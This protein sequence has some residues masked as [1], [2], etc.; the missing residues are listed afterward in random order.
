MCLV[1]AMVRSVGSRTVY[2]ENGAG[3]VDLE[4]QGV[5]VVMRQT[6][7]GEGRSRQLRSRPACLRDEVDIEVDVA[8]SKL[9]S[10]NLL[11]HDSSEV[12]WIFKPPPF[13]APSIA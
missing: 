13:D 6:E 11:A 10:P 9:I 2:S 12:V 5:S 1:G 4:R 7:G 3:K 8:V